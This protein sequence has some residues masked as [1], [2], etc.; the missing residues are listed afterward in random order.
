MKI[1][2][3]PENVL[4]RS[5]FKQIKSKREEVLVHPGVGEDCAVLGL[6]PDEV[7]VLSTDPITGA[8][9]D[10]GTLAVHV[11]AN[12][13]ASAGAEPVG[14]L[15]TILLPQSAAEA[16]LK[17]LMKEIESACESLK[18]EIIGGHT[19]VTAAV[20]QPIVTVTGV[21]KVKKDAVLFTK[22]AKPGQDIVVTKWV[23]LEGTSIIASE[24]EAELCT[25]YSREFVER[26]Q[27]FIKY[28]SVVPE[29]MAARDFG[30]SAM[31][32]VTEGGIFGALWE[33]A[34]AGGVGLSVDLK[35]VPLK[36][37]TVEI[38]EF[39]DLN[40]YQL[41]S[42]G[43]MLIACDRGHDLVSHLE[44]LGIHSAVV[45]KFTDNN[46]KIIIYDAGET[47]Y[48]EPPKTDELYKAKL[49]EE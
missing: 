11:T 3:V 39:F 49:V 22:G 35:K 40:P 21:G 17:F 25:R 38:C 48:L 10:I 41:I 44:K 26:A 4:K 5:V 46:D 43:S 28:I 20:N 34:V 16:D 18:I 8:V 15:L 1:G 27:G 7:F 6:A 13:L 29:A 47:R 23:G 9:S 36:Q 31:H 14:I 19:E 12:D 37:E 45:G 42:S 32:D 24:R 33:V 30:V 2:K